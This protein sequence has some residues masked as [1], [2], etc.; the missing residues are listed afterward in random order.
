MKS[1]KNFKHPGILSR[2]LKKKKKESF[3]NC[4]VHNSLKIVTRI[5]PSVSLHTLVA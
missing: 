4:G 3:Q 5:N 1:D 2:N